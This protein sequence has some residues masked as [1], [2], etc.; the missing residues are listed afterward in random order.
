M[1]GCCSFSLFQVRKVEEAVHQSLSSAW[2]SVLE[3]EGNLDVS[4]NGCHGGDENGVESNVTKEMWKQGGTGREGIDNGKGNNGGTGNENG[5][6]NKNGTGLQG[7]GDGSVPWDFEAALDFYTTGKGKNA[8]STKSLFCRSTVA[9]YCIAHVVPAWT[10]TASRQQNQQQVT[11]HRR[12]TWNEERLKQCQKQLMINTGLAETSST[13]FG[14]DLEI[15]SESDMLIQI[16]KTW[17]ERALSQ[18]RYWSQLGVLLHMQQIIDQG[19]PV[20]RT[21]SATQI[22]SQSQQFPEFLQLRW[23]ELTSDSVA[24]LLISRWDFA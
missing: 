22:T 10:A 20:R 18:I 12:S 3:K 23:R 7:N 19:S 9:C 8:S 24:L 15:I 1:F 5:T 17:M 4:V 2:R 14:R 13:C 6:G 21:D 11:R 16:S